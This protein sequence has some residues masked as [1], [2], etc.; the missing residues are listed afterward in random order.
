MTTQ[1]LA[2]AHSLSQP[3]SISWLSGR[4][5][6]ACAAV[7]LGAALQVN[8]GQ[9]HPLALELLTISAVF[10]AL[11]YA[12]VIRGLLGQNDRNEERAGRHALPLLYAPTRSRESMVANPSLCDVF[13]S[14]LMGSASG[15]DAAGRRMHLSARVM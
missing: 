14:G 1:S 7:T 11:A 5:G 12:G 8:Y 9:Y 10:V 2:T 3:Q 13:C 15:P 6:I 4:A